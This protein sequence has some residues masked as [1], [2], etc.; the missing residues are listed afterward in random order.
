MKVARAIA[1]LMALLGGPL[2]GAGLE[3][4]HSRLLERQVPIAVH[5]PAAE[6]LARWRAAH[7]DEPLQLV[8]FLPGAFDGPK[9]FLKTG[10][11]THLTEQEAAGHLP[12]SLWVAVTHFQSW[13]ADRK[14]GRFPYERFLMEEL[15]PQ[16]E[17]RH[18]GFGGSPRARSLAGLS[19]GG[20]GALNLAVRTGAFSKCLALSPALIEPPFRQ[21]P[22]WIRRSLARTF[23]LDPGRFEP[24]NP[25]LHL[26]GSVALVVSCGTE[27]NYDLAKACQAFAEVC[28][29]RNRRLHLELRP[30]GHDWAYWTP[31]FKAWMPWLL[32][33]DAAQE[34]LAGSVAKS[35]YGPIIGS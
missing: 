27:D 11:E 10:L 34:A 12:P 14:D 2:P 6:V 16:L 23:P 18:P 21:V 13:Y 19:M 8:L 35:E 22:W 32:D 24:W 9:D 31:A 25:R 29:A 33:R 3:S 4:I 26:G 1:I 15:I 28:A 30:G 7:P 5:V 20:F 17:A